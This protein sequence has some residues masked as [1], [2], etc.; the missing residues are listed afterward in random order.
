MLRCSGNQLYF[1]TSCNYPSSGWSSTRAEAFGARCSAPAALRSSC[2]Y[3]SSGRS[4]ISVRQMS[5]PPSSGRSLSS[6]RQ[7][8]L[9]G[10]FVI[11]SLPHA[12]INDL[13]IDLDRNT[14]WVDMTAWVKFGL[15]RPSRLA[16]HT[17]HRYRQIDKHN[18]FYYIDWSHFLRCPIRSVRN[19]E[20]T[21]FRLPHCCMTPHFQGTTA[22]IRK[23]LIMS[24]S[25][26]TGLHRRH[27]QYSQSSFKSSWWS[28]KDERVLKHGA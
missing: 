19:P 17:E 11:L 1:D 24:E 4:S 7:V 3:L 25:R 22:N 14:P 13:D 15:D 18:A 10:C 6:V 8:S 28:P 27:W 23:S 21:R 5:L 20:K 9:S 16:G 26:V 12:Y 2:N